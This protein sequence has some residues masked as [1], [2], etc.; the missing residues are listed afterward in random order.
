[1]QGFFKKG[2]FL[3][4]FQHP[5]F[6]QILWLLLAIC[7]I[8]IIMLSDS[9]AKNADDLYRDGSFAEAEKEYQ[10]SDMNNPKDIRFRYNR[11]CAAFQNSDY[12]TAEAAFSSVL[13][14]T[15]DKDI[16][17]R[18]AYNLGNTAF[19][20][21]DFTSAAEFY[22]QAIIYNPEGSEAKYNLEL[23]LKKLEEQKQN[24]D[25]NDSKNKNDKEGNQ[26][27]DNKNS[28]DKNNGKGKNDGKK[29]QQDGKNNNKDN[30][31]EDK[32]Q[33]LSGDLSAVNP[34]EG[35]TK[36]ETPASVLDRKKAE[37]LLD[38]IKE[39]RAKIMQF[40]APEKKESSGSGK[41]W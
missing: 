37:A 20:Q 3:V 17:Y 10:K 7:I 26:K 33:N 35:K 1:M 18:S 4:A 25:K 38:N 22:K 41:N 28:P 8:N 5:F 27:R 13:R 12:K 15:K 30:N 36:V 11:G 21:N 29:N 6:K 2:K 19:A 9:L 40:Q 32:E 39:D 24:Q 16:L 14:R 31:K 23:S 34:A